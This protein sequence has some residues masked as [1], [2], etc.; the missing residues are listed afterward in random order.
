MLQPDLELIPAA[1]AAAQEP[2][3]AIQVELVQE[4]QA[5]TILQE[6][7]VAM[8]LLAILQDLINTMVV[9]VVVV[10][11]LADIKVL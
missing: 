5:Q 11:T 8:A 6:E 1:V 9:A 10:A 2:Q 7:K 3:E 4:I